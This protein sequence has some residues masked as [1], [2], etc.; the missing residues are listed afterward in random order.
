MSK[1]FNIILFD[2]ITSTNDYAKE[3]FEHLK[4]KTIIVAKEQTKGRG[5]FS[6]K[7]Y[8]PKD[9]ALYTSIVIKKNLITNDLPFINLIA[10]LSVLKTIKNLS[11]LSP[12]L[13]YPNDVYIDIKKIAGILIETIFKVNKLEGIIIGIGVNINNTKFSPELSNK[14]TS[15]IIEYGKHIDLSIFLNELLKIIFQY[16]EKKID[17]DNII[18]EWTKNSPTLFNKTILLTIDGILTK[19]ITSGLD[20]NGYL[21]VKTHNGKYLELKTTDFFFPE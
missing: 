17:K 15:I 11:S 12:I 16:L 14:A 7:W 18:E 13:K 4:H 1:K 5:R 2:S 8:S 9:E 19:A 3:N 10:S 6:R 21:R 20:Y